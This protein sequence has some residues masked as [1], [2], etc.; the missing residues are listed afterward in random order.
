MRRVTGVWLTGV[1]AF[2]LG[3][4]LM[5]WLI[6]P[7]QLIKFPLN[8]QTVTRLAGTNFSYFNVTQVQELTGV[9]VQAINTTVGDV[10]AGS[11]STAVWNGF[12]AVQ[13]ETNHQAISYSTTRFAFNR[14][15]GELENCCGAAV[16]TDTK[17]NFSGQGDVWPIGAKKQ[18][19][20][21]F[22]TTINKPVP[23]TYDGT[24]TIDGE[25][26]YKYVQTVSNQQFGSQNVPGS[27]V[28]DP[29]QSSLTLPEVLTGTYTYYV[30]PTTGAPVDVIQTQSISLQQNGTTKLVL[31]N[32]TLSE[33]PASIASAVSTAKGYDTEITWVQDIVPIIAGLV[34]LVLIVL[35]ALMIA[36]GRADEEEEYEDEDED[37]VPSEA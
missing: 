9:S 21:L 27:L 32:G 17:I 30:D 1:G 13:D 26:T 4:A 31:L 19:Y 29:S 33:T 34:G 16:G 23:A 8:E 10:A 2:F 37:A 22:N 11:S 35:G 36:A 7:G 6:V 18:T 14:R 5:F 24:A 12:T 15:T 20:Q 28:G 25:N 3:I